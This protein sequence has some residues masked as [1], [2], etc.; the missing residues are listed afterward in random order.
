MKNLSL[1]TLA[2]FGLSYCKQVASDEKLPPAPSNGSRTHVGKWCR[3]PCGSE[4]AR[5]QPTDSVIHAS[6]LEPRQPTFATPRVWPPPG[7][8]STR[9]V[10]SARLPLTS[11]VLATSQDAPDGKPF[12]N[13]WLRKRLKPVMSDWAAL[14]CV[15]VRRIWVVQVPFHLGQLAER[16]A[17]WVLWARKIWPIFCKL[18]IK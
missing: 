11:P 2:N 5:R 16:G 12:V 7:F 9:L 4:N 13:G 1:H 14:S 3:S 18:W 8:A 6:S 15:C 10:R 17:V